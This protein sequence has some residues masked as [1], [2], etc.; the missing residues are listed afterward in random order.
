M[1]SLLTT[2][3]FWLPTDPGPLAIYYPPPVEIVNTQE[4]PFLDL[5]GFPTHHN[6]P[7]I[8]HAEQATIDGKF[9]R[10]KN[11]Y[12]SNMNIRRAVFNC[13]SDNIDD[14]FKVSNDPALVKWNPSMEP[15][16]I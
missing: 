12:E 6:Q 13:L 4:D 14:T 10:T 15:R 1:Y 5:A 7:T 2:T 9:K 8:V 11:Y 16:E 3:P